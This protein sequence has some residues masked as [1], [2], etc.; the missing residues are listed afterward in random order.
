MV[1]KYSIAVVATNDEEGIALTRGFLSS[2]TICEEYQGS[3]YDGIKDRD[4]DHAVS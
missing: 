1:P 2:K 4:T 3:D